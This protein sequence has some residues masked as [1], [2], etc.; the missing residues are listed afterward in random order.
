LTHLLQDVRTCTVEYDDESAQV[1]Y[2]PS[3]YTPEAEDTYQREIDAR[4]PSGGCADVLSV[5]LLSWEVLDEDGVEI[6]IE[7]ELLRG[8]PSAFLFAVMAAIVRDLNTEREDR[9]NS[10]DGLRPKASREHARNGTRSSGRRG[11]L[12]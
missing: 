9:K 6:P 1:T 7:L 8:M 10:G 5:M 2:R 11:S 12:G 4:R 3:A